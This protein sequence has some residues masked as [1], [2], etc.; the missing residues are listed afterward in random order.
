MTV[1]ESLEDVTAIFRAALPSLG[2]EWAGSWAILIVNSSTFAVSAEIC[3]FCTTCSYGISNDVIIGSNGTHIGKLAN[4]LQNSLY[5]SPT[6]A[7][8]DGRHAYSALVTGKMLPRDRTCHVDPTRVRTS[9]NSHG[10]LRLSRS[11]IPL[12]TS[13]AHCCLPFGCVR[14]CL[15][16]PRHV[17]ASPARYCPSRLAPRHLPLA[18]F[19]VAMFSSTRH[20]LFCPLPSLP[21]VTL[22]P[23]WCSPLPLYPLFLEPASHACH[24]LPRSHIL[25]A[26]FCLPRR[27]IFSFPLPLSCLSPPP[28]L[29]LPFMLAAASPRLPS[30]NDEAASLFPTSP[31]LFTSPFFNLSP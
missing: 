17:D 6:T 25:P 28:C 12:A 31:R 16:T 21:P 4:P 20:C 11:L 26:C 30:L 2:S 7:C 3:S 18:V 24:H 14:S 5:E 1:L 29:F 10:T 19:P 22:T 13:P 23:A 15:W 27:C 8:Y 9:H